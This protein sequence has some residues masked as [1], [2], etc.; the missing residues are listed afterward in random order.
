MS[1]K[2]WF[3]CSYVIREPQADCNNCKYHVQPVV[4]KGVNMVVCSANLCPLLVHSTTP[5]GR[6]Q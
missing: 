2:L 5:I 1:T 3:H 4:V 6:A